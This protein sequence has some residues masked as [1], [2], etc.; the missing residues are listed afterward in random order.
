MT[1]ASGEGAL[2]VFGGAFDPPHAAH[3]MLVAYALAVAPVERVIVVPAFQHAFG[4]DM[5][6]YADRVA[7]CERAFAHLR[8]VE[9]SRI[10]ERLGGPSYTLS[11]LEALRAEAPQRPLRLLIGADILGETARWHRFD[12]I[13]EVAPPFVVGR[14]GVDVALDAPTLPAISSTDVRA[15][16][17]DGRS[18]EHWVPRAVDGYVRAHGLYGSSK[19]EP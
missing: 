12:R 14:G 10:E 16:Y 1:P 15:R 7:M 11:T 19:V 6:P 9:V 17:R 4:K 3:V 5:A 2:G 18:V 8:D 13:R